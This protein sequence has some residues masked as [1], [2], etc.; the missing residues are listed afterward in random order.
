MTQSV[1]TLTTLGN[2]QCPIQHLVALRAHL[3]DQE[4]RT[5]SRGVDSLIQ[6]HL[7]SVS[8][9]RHL[10]HAKTIPGANV[11]SSDIAVA[12]AAHGALADA[13]SRLLRQY[14]EVFA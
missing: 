1:S 11:S 8:T 12:Q 14:E 3:D 4:R 9:L 10:E 13:I 2:T 5:E 7:Q 6:K